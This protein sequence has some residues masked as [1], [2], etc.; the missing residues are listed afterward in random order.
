MHSNMAIS[1][2]ININWYVWTD[3]K[4]KIFI[5]LVHLLKE[6]N[7]ITILAELHVTKAN[8]YFVSCL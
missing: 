7:K 5:H 6:K 1:N 3:E 4:T 8:T 2:S